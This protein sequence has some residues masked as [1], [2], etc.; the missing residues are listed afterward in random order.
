LKKITGPV[1][2]AFIPCPTPLFRVS[3]NTQISCGD[4]D[5]KDQ[6]I[7]FSGNG[8]GSGRGHDRIARTIVNYY[9]YYFTAELCPHIKNKK[10]IGSM[11]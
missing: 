11:P 3:E 6:H 4:Y 1:S 7:S 8:G 2:K 9:Y 10:V 5:V